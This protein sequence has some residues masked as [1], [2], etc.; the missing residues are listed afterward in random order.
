MN[1]NLGQ[2]KQDYQNINIPKDL[3][4]Q[5]ALAIA[6]AKENAAGK[7]GRP[8]HKK[9]S[10]FRFPFAKAAAGVAAAA[11][12]LVILANSNASIAYAM[13]QIPVLGAI[14]Q[15]VTFREYKHQE[16]KMEANLKIPEIQVA[17]SEGNIIQEATENLNNNIQDYTTKIIAAYEADVKAAG[18]KG[19]QA[20][21]LD[22]ET[23]TDNDKLFSLRFH[24]TITMAGAAQMEKI[25]HIDKTTGEM[26]TLKDLFQDGADYK[27]PISENIKAQMKEQMAQDESIIYWVDSDM[28]EW[29]FEEIA[30]DVNFYINKSGKLTIVFDEYQVAPG[31][32]GVVTFEI[33]TEAV[34][35]ILKDGYLL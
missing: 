22:Y 5:V 1:H 10:L 15:V 21:D 2:I 9:A 33:P 23:V 32:M 14:V 29:N 26:V 34:S 7:Q 24:Q 6:Q 8:A 11:F 27:T 20:V 18:G 13:G 12:L 19:T 4:A 31:S 3:E 35:D 28:T 30:E 17:D 25:Y 16:N